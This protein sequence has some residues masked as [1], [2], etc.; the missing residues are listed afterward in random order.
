MNINELNK[1]LLSDVK[2]IGVGY[3]DNYI[4]RYKKIKNRKLTAKGNIEKRNGSRV[5]GLVFEIDGSLEKL[6]R[7]EGIFNNIYQVELFNVTLLENKKKIR[8]FSYIMTKSSI[9]QIGIPCK[10]Y[11]NNIV[12]TAIKYDF[13]LQYIRTKLDVED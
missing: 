9:D 6:H 1:Y 7:K 5:Y 2:L 10:K 4:F 8:C 3:L 13:P 12:K 11:R